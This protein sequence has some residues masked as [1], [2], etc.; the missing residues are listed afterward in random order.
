M[1][2][3]MTASIESLYAALCREKLS[4]RRSPISMDKFKVHK[5]SWEKQQL[6]LVINTRTM[7]ARLPDEKLLRLVTTLNTTWY[8]HITYSKLLEG[9]T[10]L[11]NLEHA[12]SVSPW[13]RHLYYALQSSANHCLRSSMQGMSISPQL[14][15]MAAQVRERLRPLRKKYSLIE[16]SRPRCLNPSTSLRNLVLF[17]RNSALSSHLPAKFSATPLSMLGKSPLHTLHPGKMTTSTTVMHACMKSV[18]YPLI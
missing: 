10:L 11:E 18:G 2:T 4:E 3:A 6:G 5:R 14:I 9:V 16:L 1:P 8:T 15:V 13:G 7:T 17:P 12:A